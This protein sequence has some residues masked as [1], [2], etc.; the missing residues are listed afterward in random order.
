MSVSSNI[1]KIF[2][3]KIAV[4]LLAFLTITFVIR[5]FLP[6]HF[7]VL[8]LF[9]SILRIVGVFICFRYDMTIPLAKSHDEAA[10]SVVL[11]LGITGLFSLV[12]GVVVAFTRVSLAKWLHSPELAQFLWLLPCF[13]CFEGLASTLGH[14]A[15]RRNQFSAIAWS[16]ILNFLSER[17]ATIAWGLLLGGSTFGLFAGRFIGTGIGI[18]VLL[19]F[20]GTAVAGLFT[21]RPALH[22]IGT[23]AKRHKKFPMFGTWTVFINTVSLQL[24]TFILSI[25]ASNVIVGYYG[26]ANKIIETPMKMLRSSIT[27]VF[28][29]M[30]ARQYHESGSFAE[31]VQEF[32]TRLIQVSALPVT[33]V[34]WVGPELFGEFFGAHWREAG[35]YAQMLAPFTFA[36]SLNVPLKVYE[37]LD[38]QE[39]GLLTNIVITGA[40]T[41]GL[42]IGLSITTPRTALLIF[43]LTSACAHSVSLGWKLHLA[44]VPIRWGVITCLRYSAI[45]IAMLLPLKTAIVLWPDP[46]V[47][48]LFLAGAVVGYASLL[49]FLDPS[50]KILFLSIT[51]RNSQTSPITG[52]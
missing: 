42:F 47:H 5:L 49:L 24:P 3:G 52:T 7:G 44:H 50:L 51:R 1:L 39:L 41:L 35:V 2:S 29:P 10:A 20:L 33:A 13:A 4:Q 36:A 12:I 17:G 21:N 31:I 22:L 48:V 25:Y 14:W 37:I 18:G 27:K 19:L 45:A 40:R 23:V 9:D 8:L 15:A 26:L 11:S 28:F 46:G 34:A 38:K 16:D 30:A 32:V 6:E 43:F